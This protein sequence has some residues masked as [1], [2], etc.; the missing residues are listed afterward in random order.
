VDGSRI[1]SSYNFLTIDVSDWRTGRHVINV[2]AKNSSSSVM[3]DATIYVV[4]E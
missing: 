1:Q 2:L 3:R 4:I